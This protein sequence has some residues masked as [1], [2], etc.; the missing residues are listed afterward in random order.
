MA[1]LTDEQKQK[2]LSDYHTNK[3]S[4]RELAKKHNVSLGSINKL[5]KEVSPLNEHIVDA[6]TIVLKA[7]KELSDE[8]MNAVMNTASDILRRQ[9]LVYGASEK[10]LKRTQEIIEKNITID[11]ISRDGGQEF[12]YRELNTTDLKNLA[13]TVDKA[14]ITLGVNQR[15]ANSQ[16]TV[17]NT[18]A[19]QNNNGIDSNAITQALK[20]KYAS[21]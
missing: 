8:Q 19:Q 14:S 2:I 13:D 1:R 21:R 9:N 7:Q 3:Y 16:V 5:T 4:Q 10:L 11:R 20:D 17:N 6:Q 18:N 15:H 12:A